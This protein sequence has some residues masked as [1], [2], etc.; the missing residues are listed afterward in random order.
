MTCSL[1]MNL[2]RWNWCRSSRVKK[3]KAVTSALIISLNVTRDI[4]SADLFRPSLTSQGETCHSLPWSR[5]T[6]AA[7][8]SADPEEQSRKHLSFIHMFRKQSLLWCELCECISPAVRGT[9][10]S[11]TDD[12]YDD[13][14]ATAAVW[15][16]THTHTHTHTHW[17]INLC[18]ASTP[19]VRLWCRRH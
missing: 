2:I 16:R 6:P 1:E 8:R 4:S 13:C 18:K 7:L 10:G 12:R 9:G 5:R 15:R 3:E 11:T 19:A 14:C 17:I